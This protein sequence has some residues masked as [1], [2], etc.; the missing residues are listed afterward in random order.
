MIKQL[1]KHLLINI[2]NMLLASECVVSKAVS[3]C[4][5]SFIVKHTHEMSSY[6]LV[7]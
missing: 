3:F 2:L 6:V 5:S 7:V 1:F 4:D